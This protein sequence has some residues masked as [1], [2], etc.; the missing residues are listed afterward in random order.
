[1]LFYFILFFRKFAIFFG[2]IFSNVHLKWNGK[3][4]YM[5][6]G[7]APSDYPKFSVA[8][9]GVITQEEVDI[10]QHL[11]F[12]HKVHVAV[13]SH[14]GSVKPGESV[15]TVTPVKKDK[16]YPFRL[17]SVAMVKKEM[18]EWDDKATLSIN[19]ENFMRTLYSNSNIPNE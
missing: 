4:R 1:M 12:P 6:T 10:H 7:P 11:P 9:N 19:I 15:I 18:I 5:I 2:G 14:V 8:I 17:V 3:V 13:A 16:K